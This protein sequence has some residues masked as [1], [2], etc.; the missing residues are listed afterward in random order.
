MNQLRNYNGV[1][2]PQYTPSALSTLK[3]DEVFVFG[4]NL[5]QGFHQNN[6]IY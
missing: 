5:R 6:I 1:E 4:S 2:R 3:F